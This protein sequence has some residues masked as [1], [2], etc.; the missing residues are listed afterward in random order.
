M[1]RAEFFEY[2]AGALGAKV[3]P[4]Q[5]K[6]QPGYEGLPE[7]WR[8]IAGLE[9]QA[10]LSCVNQY[11]KPLASGEVPVW[12]RRLSETL[13]GVYAAN[14]YTSERD[15]PELVLL[16]CLKDGSGPQPFRAWIGCLPCPAS[17]AE[18]WLNFPDSLRDFYQN[19]HDGFTVDTGFG[20]VGLRRSQH[21]WTPA[22]FGSVDDYEYLSDGNDD[23]LYL[24]ESEW[25][26]L[27]K[28]IEVCSDGANNRVCVD[29]S[30]N[31]DLGW[32]WIGGELTRSARPIWTLIDE[33]LR[34]Y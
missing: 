30:T 31:L 33:C 10:A 21:F 1:G 16:Y 13:H 17:S 3:E 27:D 28:L 34:Y 29:V 8:D 7:Y 24:P 5:L 6:D 14:L 25:P 22:D 12:T 18:Y 23:E 20:S 2:L 26:E 15:T 11:W 9:N 32:T 4:L 19:I